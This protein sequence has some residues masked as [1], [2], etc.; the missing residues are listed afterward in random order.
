MVYKKAWYEDLYNRETYLDLYAEAD[1]RIAPRQV[2]G[3]VELLGLAPGGTVLD[4]CCGYRRHAVELARRG[5]RVTGID[6]APRQIDAATEAAKRAGVQIE[7]LVGDAREMTFH[8]RFD[9]SLSLFTSLGFF[10]ADAD[11]L[12]VLERIAAATA[13]GGQFLMD[14]WNTEQQIRKISDHEVEERSDGVR[15]ERRGNFDA[16]RSRLD[17]ENTVVFPDGRTE[18]WDQS[19]RA[20]TLGEL[21]G[22]LAGPGLPVQAVHGD[23]QGAEFDR[24][25]PQMITVSRK[26]SS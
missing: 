22:M 2:D 7:L 3:L 5:Y 26:A 21:T 8:D 1:T 25:S 20:Y 13:P 24:D 6:L 23:F 9:V 11:N 16:V 12:R 14:T 15:I 4:V 17:W 10:E 19:M 18:R